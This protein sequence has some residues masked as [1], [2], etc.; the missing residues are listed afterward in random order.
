M[1]AKGA[2]VILSRM[3]LTDEAV[4]VVVA[5]YGQGI[6][7]IDDFVQLNEKSVEG[8]C[9]VLRRSRGTTGGVSNPGFSVPVMAESN[10]QGMIYYIKHFRMI[11][12]TCTHADFDLSKVRKM[13]HHRD[14]EDSHKYPEVLP[15]VDPRYWPK[16][17][18]TVE[19]YVRGF[20]GVYGQPLKP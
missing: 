16:T 8:L 5:K 15:T 10:P 2:K 4:G 9:Q 12:Y 17:L 14:M 18:E 11:G 20:R 7:T 13:Y 3:N 1:A 6:I 19:E